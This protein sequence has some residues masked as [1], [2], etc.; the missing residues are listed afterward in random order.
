MNRNNNGAYAKVKRLQYEP[1]TR[2]NIV[3]D[4]EGR[5]EFDNEKIANRWKEYMEELY[6]SLEITIEDQYIENYEQ[7]DNNMKRPLI[8]DDELNKPLKE[9]SDKKST[10]VDGI[11]AE[12]LK[13]LDDKTKKPYFNS[14]LVLMNTIVFPRI[15]SIVEPSQYPKKEMLRN[16]Q[17]IEQL[18]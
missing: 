14:S 15:S 7:V 3:K 5:I 6:A 11:P 18:L 1:K 13:S 12:I 16:A 9:L 4:K 10:G 2:S 17:I 8:D